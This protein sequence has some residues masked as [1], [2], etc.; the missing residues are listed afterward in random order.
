MKAI[1]VKGPGQDM[2]DVDKL[3]DIVPLVH[4]FNNE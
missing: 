3:L 1:H 4:N 2:G